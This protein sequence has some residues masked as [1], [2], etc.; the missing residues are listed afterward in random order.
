MLQ[1]IPTV[2]PVSGAAQ[3]HQKVISTMHQCSTSHVQKLYN[4]N[5]NTMSHTP[6]T[7]LQPNPESCSIVAFCTGSDGILGKCAYLTQLHGW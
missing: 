3:A 6:Y 1:V 4:H 2:G 5:P 7:L